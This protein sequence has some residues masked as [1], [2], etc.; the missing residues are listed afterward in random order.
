MAAKPAD[1]TAIAARYDP[2]TGTR[3][4]A[5]QI[6]I[7]NGKHHG[8]TRTIV[9]SDIIAL[10]QGGYTF[11]TATRNSRGAWQKSKEIKIVT[12]DGEPFIRSSGGEP[13]ATDELDGLA[14]F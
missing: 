12:L 4:Q 1:Y 6:R 3:I 11:C 2:A 14:G 10:L 8:L 9:R 7:N 13:V 5:V